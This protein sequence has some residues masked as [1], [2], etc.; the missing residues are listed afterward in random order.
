MLATVCGYAPRVRAWRRVTGAATSE[1]FRERLVPGPLPCLL[2][3]AAPA[4]LGI[5]Y[6]A[7]FTP[8]AGWLIFV[9]GFAAL[10]VL[11][12]MGSPVITVSERELTAGRA[13]LPRTVIADLT[14]LDGV[15]GHTLRAALRE[16]AAAYTVLRAWAGSK[17]LR[18]ALADAEDPHPAWVL[19][20]RRP[21][22]LAQALQYGT[23]RGL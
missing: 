16:D 13:R 5:A 15:D 4:A 3:A 19:S 20:T 10:A 12:A 14:V 7:A 6:G 23:G 1:V 22:A 17:G 9:V 8:L 18:I 11:V 21:K 2:L